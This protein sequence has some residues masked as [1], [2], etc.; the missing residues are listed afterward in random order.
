MSVDHDREMQIARPRRQLRM[1]LSNRTRTLIAIGV[2]LLVA[3]GS[4]ILVCS[5][6]TLMSSMAVL[7]AEWFLY[8][9]I[10]QVAMIAA[11]VRTGGFPRSLAGRLTFVAVNLEL[12]TVELLSYQH[13]LDVGVDHSLELGVR[14]AII[15][16]WGLVLAGLP[17]VAWRVWRYSHGRGSAPQTLGK[18][19]FSAAV[20]LLVGEPCALLVERF[21]RQSETVRLPASLPAAPDG[22]LRIAAIGESTMAGFPYTKRFGIAEVVA[23]RLGEASPGRKVVLD[24]MAEPGLNLQR[25]IERAGALPYRPHLLLLY[26]GHNEFFYD[27]DEFFYDHEQT[28]G[29]DTSPWCGLDR[30]L[31]WSPAF[32][33][34]DRRI[35]RRLVRRVAVGRPSPERIVEERLASAKCQQ[36]RLE[37]FHE[38]LEQLAAWCGRLQIPTLWFVPA[39]LEADYEPN[40]SSL[41]HRATDEERDDLFRI[42]GEA[43]SLQLAGRYGQAADIYRRSLDRYPGFAAFHFRLAECQMRLGDRKDAARNYAL[44]LESDG[45]PIRMLEPFRRQ[46]A[47]TASRFGVPTIDAQ[48]VLRPC[49]PFGI[50]DRSVFLDYAHPNLRSYYLLGMAAFAKVEEA[51]LLPDFVSRTSVQTAGPLVAIQK[52]DRDARRIDFASAIKWA[53]FGTADLSLAYL[54]TAEAEKSIARLRRESTQLIQES[55]RFRDWSRRLK[56]GVLKPGQEGTESLE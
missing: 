37:R 42:T 55:E 12:V 24:N 48:D 53:R 36:Y 4:V 27:H 56:T 7:R 34:F 11:I 20:L 22:E 15:G 50:L 39:G 45:Y 33:L 19:W 10:I 5:P 46:V 30:W 25:A 44:A 41:S 18:L 17:I 31:N 47:E 52:N 49:T 9:G 1:V 29:D 8:V 54:R 23:W 40:R 14:I 16:T 13:L 28:S 26:S 6:E 35:S 43:K 32:T 21:Y 3:V 51:K 38:Q 2:G